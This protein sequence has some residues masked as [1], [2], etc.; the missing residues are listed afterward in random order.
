MRSIG[1]LLRIISTMLMIILITL[2]GDRPFGEEAKDDWII[3]SVQEPH[4]PDGAT[5]DTT[6]A[7]ALP[8]DDWFDSMGK[9]E[10]ESE[11]EV[12]YYFVMPLLERLGYGEDDLAVGQ[13]V[14]IF[15]GV[16]KVKKEA[17]VVVYDGLDRDTAH[18]LIVVEAKRSGSVLTADAAGQA[19]GYAMWTGTPYY[20]VTNSHEVQV[21][22]FRSAV[23]SDVRLMKF[24]RSDLRSVWADL[25]AKLSKP[26]VVEYKRRLAKSMS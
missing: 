20:L 12:E 15:E 10:F 23:Q 16:K 9:R 5:T 8:S 18:A 1:R 17:D 11:R 3:L 14:E 25:H 21:W 19:R 2:T 26:A 4:P 13:V 22:L 24:E 6:T 7:T